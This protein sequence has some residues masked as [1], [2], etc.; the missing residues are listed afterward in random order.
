MT[1]LFLSTHLQLLDQILWSEG[2]IAFLEEVKR[3]S[4]RATSG[5]IQFGE[6]SPRKFLVGWAVLDFLDALL[7]IYVRIN[8]HVNIHPMIMPILH[9]CPG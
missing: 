2:T 8:P 6:Y 3:G 1:V 4:A 5:T 9:I 7:V